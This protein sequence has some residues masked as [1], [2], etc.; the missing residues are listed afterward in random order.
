MI[1]KGRLEI[2]SNGVRHFW[3]VIYEESSSF[4]AQC[5]L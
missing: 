2:E 1:G 4:T 5:L 3:P